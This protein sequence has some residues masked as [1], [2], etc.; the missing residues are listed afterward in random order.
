M[1]QARDAHECIYV[2]AGE[3]TDN[4][5]AFAAKHAIKL[6]GGPELARL[7]PRSSV[8]MQRPG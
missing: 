4:A 1:K 6:V 5:R 7:L 8:S 2:A 3:I